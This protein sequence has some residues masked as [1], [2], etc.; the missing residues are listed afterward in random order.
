MSEENADVAKENA[1]TNYELVC[2]VL[3]IR[4]IQ[5]EAQLLEWYS[6]LK[7]NP[8]TKLGALYDAMG[9]LYRPIERLVACAKGCTSCCNYAVSITDLEATFIERGT[10]RK[11]SK[12]TDALPPFHGQA[13]PFLSNGKCGIY[14]HR[15]F[16]CRRHYALTKTAYWCH[17]ERAF[18]ERFPMLQMSEVDKV[19]DKLKRD[20]ASSTLGD[21]REVFG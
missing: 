4:L 17:P 8:V 7:G 1:R 19:F 11:R 21:I 10:G 5:K 6:K 9:E 15:P 13:C 20:A 2:S 12:K 3:S 18:S 16:V 14:A